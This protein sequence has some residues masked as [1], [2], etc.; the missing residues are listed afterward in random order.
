M[1]ARLRLALL[2]VS[3]VGALGATNSSHSTYNIHFPAGIVTTEQA[4]A[5]AASALQEQGYQGEATSSSANLQLQASPIWVAV[6]SP[7]PGVLEL[8]FTQLRGGCG[9]N[10][11]VVG[12]RVAAE[13]VQRAIEARVGTTAAQQ[14]HKANALGVAK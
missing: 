11:E 12:S 7:A 4:V 14:S 3:L 8:S 5:L 1:N 13:S 9:H 2:L 10:P 6:H